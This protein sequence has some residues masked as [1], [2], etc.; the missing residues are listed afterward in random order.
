[1]SL[2]NHVER[3]TPR[4]Q[5]HKSYLTGLQSKP[6]C[7]FISDALIVS[8]LLPREARN[9]IKA[10]FCRVSSI[11]RSKSSISA[12]MNSRPSGERRISPPPVAFLSNELMVLAFVEMFIV[13]I[14]ASDSLPLVAASYINYSDSFCSSL[15]MRWTSSVTLSR[16][17]AQVDEILRNQKRLPVHL[18]PRR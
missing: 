6:S 3:V 12:K 18:V 11:S 7:V 4:L 10:L 15:P 17:P 5:E 16:L 13:F 9:F 1:M 8:V 14:V 2:G